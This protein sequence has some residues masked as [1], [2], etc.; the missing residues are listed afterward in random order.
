MVYPQ[1]TITLTEGHFLS[2]YL[3]KKDDYTLATY[4]RL[5]KTQVSIKV[6]SGSVNIM[7]VYK[8]TTIQQKF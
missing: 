8:E 1:T 3:A 4:N 6:H 2:D 7:A 5:E